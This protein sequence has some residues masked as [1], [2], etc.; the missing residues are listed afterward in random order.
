MQAGQRGDVI[1]CDIVH[2]HIAHAAGLPGG[3]SVKVA[4]ADGAAIVL[5]H[6]AA[7]VRVWARR[8]AAGGVAI[9]DTAVVGVV[10]NQAANIVSGTGDG[11]RGIGIF[12]GGIFVIAH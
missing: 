12:N 4:A 5:S 10:A 3:A 11:A 8:D 6:Q 7:N 1:R 2:V 9:A